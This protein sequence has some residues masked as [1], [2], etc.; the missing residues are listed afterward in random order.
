M[1]HCVGNKKCTFEDGNV[2]GKVY[3]SLNEAFVRYGVFYSKLN[4]DESMVPY[5]GQHRHK[6]F[7]GSKPTKFGYKIW[8]LCHSDCYAY[9]LSKY[10]YWQITRH[11]KTAGI[12]CYECNSWYCRK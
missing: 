6:M 2:D 8:C 10:L 11:Q 1:V 12:T 9:P 3:G 7:I 4:I 5:F